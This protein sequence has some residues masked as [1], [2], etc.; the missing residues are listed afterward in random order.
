MP[1]AML[2]AAV[3]ENAEAVACDIFLESPGESLCCRGASAQSF[4][5]PLKALCLMKSGRRFAPSFQPQPAEGEI[6]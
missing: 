4:S 2:D 6:I 3:R 1:Q 5:D